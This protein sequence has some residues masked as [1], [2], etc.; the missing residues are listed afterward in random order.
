MAVSK[1]MLLVNPA[2]FFET[3][4]MGSI[5]AEAETPLAKSLIVNMA[6]AKIVLGVLGVASY[7]RGSE[8]RA[9]IGTAQCRNQISRRISPTFEH[10]DHHAIDATQLDSVAA[11]ISH[12]RG[13]SRGPT[14]DSL[15][16]LCTGT[17][18]AVLLVASIYADVAI[19]LEFELDKRGRATDVPVPL[20]LT[21]PKCLGKLALVVPLLAALAAH[22]AEP[23]LLTKDKSKDQ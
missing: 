9:R 4:G 10:H 1:L 5:V 2:A 8:T 23:G 17:A 22:L 12:R 7:Y 20:D 19:P 13:P 21:S 16:A 3:M 14:P 18:I 6:V 15:V 11:W